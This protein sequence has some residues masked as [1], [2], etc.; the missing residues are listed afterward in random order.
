MK[1]L[2]RAIG[3]P[4]LLGEYRQ[5]QSSAN[6]DVLVKYSLPTVFVKKKTKKPFIEAQSCPCI[7]VLSMAAFALQWQS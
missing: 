3:T 2:K 4:S 1:L 6:Y 7:R 5:T